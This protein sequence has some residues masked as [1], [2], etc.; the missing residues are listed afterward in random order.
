MKWEE[1]EYLI[2]ESEQKEH[3]QKLLYGDV[4]RNYTPNEKNEVKKKIRRSV[5]WF[6]KLGWTRWI[7]QEKIHFEI[8]PGIDRLAKL[9][10]REINHV[11]V[12][13]EYLEGENRQP[14]IPV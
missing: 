9:Y 10:S 2:E 7:D 1:L 11:D 6:E 3:W 14:E 4:R 8:L 5:S 13:L 12:I